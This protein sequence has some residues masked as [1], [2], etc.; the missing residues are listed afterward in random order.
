MVRRGSTVR[1]RQRALS[2]KNTC[3]FASVV[4]STSTTENF[5]LAARPTLREPRQPQRA[6]KWACRPARQSTSVEWRGS[7]VWPCA[8]APKDPGKEHIQDRAGR[9]SAHT[10]SDD[11]GA[12][13]TYVPWPPSSPVV[14]LDVACHAGGC[15]F[16]SRRSRSRSR[17]PCCAS[18][19]DGLHRGGR[20]RPI[21]ICLRR[22]LVRCRSHRM[23]SSR[24]RGKRLCPRCSV[25]RCALRR[26]R[27]A[28]S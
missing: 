18:D 1:V 26:S 2:H 13:K 17:L 15:G 19:D 7:T 22:R 24:G 10:R 4:V 3:K 14:T 20:R 28:P 11:H 23:G 12:G 9:P 27:S 6:C 16:E 21:H 25:R 8:E 5:P